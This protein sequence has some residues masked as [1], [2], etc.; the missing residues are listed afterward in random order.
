M[1][2]VVV[3]V[4]VELIYLWRED[5]FDLVM[6]LYWE[7]GYWVWVFINVCLIYILMFVIEKRKIYFIEIDYV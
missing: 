6:V 1:G 2:Y 5:E 7:E 4:D 3:M